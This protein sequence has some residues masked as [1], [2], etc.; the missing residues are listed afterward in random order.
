MLVDSVLLILAAAALAPYILGPVLVRLSQRWPPRPAFE[1][2]DPIRHPLPD[3]LA[4]SFRESVDALVRLGFRLVADLAHTSPITKIQLRVAL[5]AADTAG[6]YT[7]VIGGRSTNPKTKVSTCYVDFPTKF[8]DGTTLSVTNNT[9]PGAYGPPPG[10]VVERL[11]QVRD[12]A[13]L[14][15]VHAAL[16]DRRYAGRQPVAVDVATNPAG[17]VGDALARDYQQQVGTG[18]LWLDERGQVFRPTWLGAWVMTWR[19]LPPLRHILEARVRR[20]AAA[21][22]ADLGLQG[23][24]ERPILA[25][26]SADP[27]RWNFVLLVAVALLY[28]F[29]RTPSRGRFELPAG[30]TVPAD[31][32]GAVR[33]LEGL[34]GDTAVPL[35]GTTANGDPLPTPGVVMDVHEATAEA[36]IAA[37]QPRFLAQG[38]YLFLSE[39]DRLALFPRSNP[40]E[41]LA[42]MGTNGWNYDI[43]PDSIIAWLRALE[44]D[45]S[46]V[47]TGIG[48]DWVQGRFVGEIRDADALAR[49]FYA[50]C[51]DIVDQGTGSVHALARE[52][53]ASRTL[54]CW[55]D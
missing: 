1:P 21:L 39:R 54:Y 28:V 14:R 29:V 9:E 44:R 2:Y 34:V 53:R 42:L 43:A 10:G 46:F 11:P 32:T 6:E 52:L 13:R 24:D 4:A 8:A 51:P 22:L 38:F 12:P 5:L 37:A 49:R 23:R 33:A 7:L 25:P 31:F 45:H 47:L 50:F 41:I 26:P 27:L 15:R 40:Y 3:Q 20:H 48:F 35:V 55:W 19:L 16:L 36:V 18:V 17:F 30:F